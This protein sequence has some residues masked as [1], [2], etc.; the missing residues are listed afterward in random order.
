MKI[1]NW[2]EARQDEIEKV[3][4][5]NYQILIMLFRTYLTVGVSE[6]QH[7]VVRNKESWEKGDITDP[8]VL[9]NDPE[10]KFRSLHEDKLWVT[11]Y[12]M[13]AKMLDLTMVIGNL[14]KKLDSKGKHQS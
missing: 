4:G 13:K 14:T 2:F 7:F 11:N 10:S 1:N 8:F 12:P 9:T 3:G 6:F 5:Q